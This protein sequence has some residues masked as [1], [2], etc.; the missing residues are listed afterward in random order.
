MPTTRINV[1][2]F[3]NI[4]TSTYLNYTKKQTVLNSSDKRQ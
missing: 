1:E 2:S 3:L 4:N